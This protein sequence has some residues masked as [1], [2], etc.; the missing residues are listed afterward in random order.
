MCIN[1]YRNKKSRRRIENAAPVLDI[2]PCM[3]RDLKYYILHRKYLE[4]CTPVALVL[5]F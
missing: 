4:F 3:Q 5:F 2:H 1:R